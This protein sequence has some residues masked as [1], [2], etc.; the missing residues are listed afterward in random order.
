VTRFYIDSSLITPV[1][2]GDQWYAFKDSINNVYRAQIAN[3]G[4]VSNNGTC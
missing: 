1:M 3:G 2:G 4:F